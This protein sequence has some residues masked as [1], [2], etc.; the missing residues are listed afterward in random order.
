MVLLIHAWFWRHGGN[1]E[2]AFVTRWEFSF[3]NPNIPLEKDAQPNAS[4][5]G[6]LIGK[7]WEP[8]VVCH[9]TFF[10]TPFRLQ[11]HCTVRFLH[12]EA[13]WVFITVFV[14]CRMSPLGF[15]LANYMLI[16][17]SPGQLGV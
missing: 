17:Q 13:S 1:S 2:V 12:S 11:T 9:Y 7:R 5:A 8:S 4:C 6:G 16:C 10:P 15:L 3:C 14:D